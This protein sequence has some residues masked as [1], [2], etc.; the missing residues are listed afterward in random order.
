MKT[1][2]I[3]MSNDMVRS[4][5]L[6]LKSETRRVMKKPPAYPGTSKFVFELH[7]FAP[8]SFEGTPAE[9]L[10]IAPERKVWSY[11]DWCGNLVGTYGDCPYGVVG[12]TLWVR[13][14]FATVNG[15][16]IYQADGKFDHGPRPFKWK[17]SIFMRPT[18]SRITLKLTEISVERLADITP[19]A[20]IAEG[21]DRVGAPGDWF[22]RDYC[23]KLK[24][25]SAHYLA[26]PVESYRSLWRKINGPHSWEENPWVWVLKFPAYGR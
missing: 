25:G 17:P 3:L 24:G 23:W 5:L 11:E 15:K 18:E 4:Y 7:P 21:L 10:N 6:G 14:N 12:D 8:S 13:E 22:Y 2:P 9:G 20:A 19:E 26:D 16:T 1:R